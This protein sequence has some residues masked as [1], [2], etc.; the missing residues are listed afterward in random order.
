MPE[1]FRLNS[2]I[3]MNSLFISLGLPSTAFK[4]FNPNT[5]LTFFDT[6]VNVAQ[7]DELW[8]FKGAD[9]YRYNLRQRKFIEPAASMPITNFSRLA[10][11]HLPAL[12][13]TGIS[14]AVYAG[15]AFP[16][17]FYFF[18]DETY[19]RLNAKSPT[20]TGIQPNMTLWETDEGPRGVLGVWAVGAWTNPDGTFK[21]RGTM[22]GLHGEGTRFAGQVHFFRN[23]EYIRHNLRTGAAAA[24]PVAIKDAWKLSSPF[25]E[26]IDLAFYGAGAEAQKIFFFSGSDFVLYDPEL[27]Q[28]IRSGSVETEFPGFD[29]FMTR[30]QLF[31]VENMSLRTY[32]GPLQ[33]GS[34]VDSRSIGAGETL[35]RVLVIETIDESTTSVKFNVLEQQD[36]TTVQ[37]FNQQINDQTSQS[38]AAESFKHNIQAAAHGDISA[39]S[40]WG[41]EVNANFDEQGGTD[42][43]R[44]DFADAVFTAVSSQVTQSRQQQVAKTF[45]S[46]TEI[47]HKERVLNEIE[48]TQQNNTNQTINIGFFQLMESFIGLLVL[49]SVKIA[50]LDGTNTRIV[51]LPEF[52]KLLDDVLSSSQPKDPIIKYVVNELSH[53]VD[54]N[55]NKQSLLQDGSQGPDINSALIT[56]TTVVT[57]DGST[58]TLTVPGIVKAMKDWLNP[59][60][61]MVG[62]NI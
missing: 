16:T 45:S 40:F 41:G 42:R 59:T 5:P 25:T 23:G 38:T 36:A 1:S 28:V 21:R 26:R 39:D 6:A 17:L 34:L 58:Q 14:T 31:L 49:G 48:F 13:F 4:S 56:T 54:A 29:R 22:V 30:P 37:N 11:K 18:S 24:G 62:R 19:V 10:Q 61:S 9:F 52:S 32:L 35:H 2:T 43:L 60:N 7:T 51:N 53:I 12:F 27:D 20:G 50:Y 8:L 55:N 44:K 46:T 3:A 33:D 47:D 15:S 57:P